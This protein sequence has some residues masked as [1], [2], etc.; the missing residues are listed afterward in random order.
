MIKRNLL[1]IGCVVALTGLI[2]T[3]CKTKDTGSTNET[4]T[5][6]IE[7]VSTSEK[8]SESVTEVETTT[9]IET[10]KIAEI[11]VTQ[12]VTEAPKPVVTQSVK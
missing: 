6:V 9:E 12:P 5:T 11:E 7:E 8:E 4:A 1:K 10:E 2:L 3:G